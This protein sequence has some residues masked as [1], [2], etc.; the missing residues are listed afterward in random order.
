MLVGSLPAAQTET[1]EYLSFEKQQHQQSYNVSQGS[2]GRKNR[3][4]VLF[5]M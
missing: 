2:E 3:K 5:L 1:G 4:V